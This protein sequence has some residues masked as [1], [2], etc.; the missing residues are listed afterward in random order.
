MII[1]ITVENL[2]E[3]Y[4]EEITRRERYSDNRTIDSYEKGQVRSRRLLWSTRKQPRIR[5]NIYEPARTPHRQQLYSDISLINHHPF[6][7]RF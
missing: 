4:E 2:R 1:M 6:W 7:L 3:K 5:T